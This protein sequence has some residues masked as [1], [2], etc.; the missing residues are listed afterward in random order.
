MGNLHPT[1]KIICEDCGEN[2]VIIYH[3]CTLCGK[4]TNIVEC[5]WCQVCSPEG[6]YSFAKEKNVMCRNCINKGI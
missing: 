5:V 6:Y 2:Q 1:N 3:K 4:S